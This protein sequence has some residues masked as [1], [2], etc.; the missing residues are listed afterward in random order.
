MEELWRSEETET[1]SLSRCRKKTS[2]QRA[3]PM[4]PEVWR[5]ERKKR[6]KVGLLTECLLLRLRLCPLQ[7]WGGTQADK[8]TPKK[9]LQC[10]CIPLSF[11]S[12]LLSPRYHSSPHHHLREVNDSA[13]KVESRLFDLDSKPAFLNKYS[14]TRE[15]WRV[16]SLHQITGYVWGRCFP[17]LGPASTRA[18]YGGE[19]TGSSHVALTR[20]GP[21]SFN[22]NNNDLSFEGQNTSRHP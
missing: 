2:Y 19:L 9:K 14:V 11:S 18:A 5:R 6:K 4:I 8:N 1:W 15:R 20:N 16:P 22:L 7:L 21:V 3:F 10:L 13:V 12:C 17:F